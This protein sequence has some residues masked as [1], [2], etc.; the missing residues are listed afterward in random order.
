MNPVQA[1][2]LTIALTKGRILTETLPLFAEAGIEPL[3]A[4]DKSRKLIF[5]TT[6]P[7]VSFVLLR[8]SD[9][10]TYVRHGAA[11]VGVVGKDLL[12]EFG[13]E[14][15]YEVLDL[16]IARCRLMTAGSGHDRRPASAKM[17][18]A[19]KFVNVARAHYSARG[20]QANIIKLYGAM[21]LAPIMNLADEI[22][23]IVDTGNTLKA[24]GMR[25]L[26]HIADVS[27]RLIVNK[28]SMRTRNPI[29]AALIEQ[30]ST[31]VASRQED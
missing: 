19:T 30:I 17:R 4:I 21:E 2:Q 20:I 13:E 25:P 16:G 28:A 7:G 27:S 15:L 10:P 5:E 11:D 6:V 29:I 23:D 31:A 14:G 18:V 22:V 1:E 24:N 12:M 26:E 9:V 8:G 3:E